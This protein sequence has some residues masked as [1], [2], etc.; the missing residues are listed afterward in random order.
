MKA[1]FKKIVVSILTAE[2]RLLLHRK[3][4]TIVAVTGSVGKTSAKDAIYAA[5]KDT[6]PSRKS[7]K[8]FNSEVGVPLTILG[9]HNGWSNPFIWL[10]NIIDGAG[11]ALFA[12]DY[13]AVLVLELGIDQPGDMDRLTSWLTPDV[14]VLTRLPDVPTHVEYFHSP[15]AVIDE[16]ML[17][18]HRMKPNGVLVYN[19]DDA[20]IAAQL[21]T[22]R[23]KTLP[24][25]RYTTAD[26]STAKDSVYY[27]DDIPAGVRFTIKTPDDTEQIELADVV[28]TQFMYAVAAAVAT[29][30]HLGVATQSAVAGLRKVSPPPGRMR[31]LPGVK[32]SVLI[33]DSY[34]SSPIAVEH[35]L[36]TMTEVKHTARRVAV[37]GD[38]LELGKY[39]SAEHKR[40]GEK[41]ARTCD[42]LLTVGVRAR[43][44][45]EGA[46][47]GGLDESAIFQYE[48]TDRAGREL[49]QLLQ[50]GDL[51]LIKGS[52]GMRTERIVR[53]VMAEP[54]RAE[55]LLVRQEKEWQVI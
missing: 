38:M 26:V 5:I 29:A 39:S 52:Q 1:F 35:A 22:V 16:K 49:Q 21:P 47:L 10:W 27:Q 55:E 36:D 33:D 31:V 17:L 28:G 9:L 30:R 23:Q 53:E 2:A 19:A 40:L 3:N 14:V 41:I 7:Q 18:V 45:A 34:N 46:L 24:Y 13:P 43:G 25:A 12:K 54:N 15:Q 42:M 8:S 6:V 11:I 50:P 48:K 20:I 51:V 4:P 37:L 44:F 32:G